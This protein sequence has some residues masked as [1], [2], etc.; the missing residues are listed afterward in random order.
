MAKILKYQNFV[1]M[2]KYNSNPKIRSRS[3]K[4]N[5]LPVIRNKNAAYFVSSIFFIGQLIEKLK[6]I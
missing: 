5:H 3:K 2:Y 1:L 4:E 6:E